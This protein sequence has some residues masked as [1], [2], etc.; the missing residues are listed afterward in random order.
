MA[1]TKNVSTPVVIAVYPKISKPDTFGKFASGKF[2]TGFKFEKPE[3]TKK[4]Q[5]WCKAKAKELMPKVAKHKFP[6]KTDEDTGEV[7]FTASSKYRPLTVDSK[8]NKLPETVLIGG[9]TKMKL[10]LAPSSYE[11][12]LSFYLNAV[13]VVEL[14]EYK[15]KAREDMDSPFEAIDDG[16]EFTGS[17]SSEED[18]GSDEGGEE[19]GFA[20]SSD[21]EAEP[22]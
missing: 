5:D 21:D 15:P 16:F 8:N 6:W 3:Q 4:F 18:E 2:K 7:T 14:M 19:A 17:V 12:R 1:E 9:G 13:Q 22:F 11:N 10:Q 20:A